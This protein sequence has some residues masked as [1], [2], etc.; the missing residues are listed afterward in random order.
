MRSILYPI[1]DIKKKKEKERG[2][3]RGKIRFHYV[4]Q[5]LILGST[6]ILYLASSFNFF[7]IF[8]I[9]RIYYNSSRPMYIIIT[10]KISFDP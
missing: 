1:K 8:F 5:N 4:G 7:H 6:V 9:Y 10:I 2:K 3:E